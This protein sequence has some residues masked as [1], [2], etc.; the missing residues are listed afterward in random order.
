MSFHWK[1]VIRLITGRLIMP[2]W[3]DAVSRTGEKMIVK[4]IKMLDGAVRC[5]GVCSSYAII[6]SGQYEK[7][8]EFLEKPLHYIIVMDKESF[9]GHMDDTNAKE[10]LEA[11]H[12]I[13]LMEK[14][15]I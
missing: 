15:Q 4:N 12:R 14:G 9:S 8:M 1:D 5:V 10:V 13:R 11:Y 6:F 2:G 3:V 7:S